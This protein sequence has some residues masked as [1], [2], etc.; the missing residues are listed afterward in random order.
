MLGLRLSQ[1]SGFNFCLPN[2]IHKLTNGDIDNT[3]KLLPLRLITSSFTGTI[4]VKTNWSLVVVLSW[5]WELV[6]YH[7]HH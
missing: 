5:V 3:A 2:T 1:C 6:I 7:Y 4:A